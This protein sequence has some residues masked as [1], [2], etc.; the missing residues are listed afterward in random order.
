MIGGLSVRTAVSTETRDLL[1]KLCGM[2]GSDFEGERATAALKI[3]GLL[4]QVGLCW[5]DVLQVPDGAS[6]ATAGCASTWSR[7][8]DWDARPPFVDWR[9]DLACCERYRSWLSMAELEYVDDLRSLLR[10]GRATVRSSD[11]ME[12]AAVARRIREQLSQRRRYASGRWEA[13]A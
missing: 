7:G 9:A 2:L 4:R 1:V 8:G 13:R 12:L 5:D 10:A 3:T 11:T 6:R